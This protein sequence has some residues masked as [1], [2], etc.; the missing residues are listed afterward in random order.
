MRQERRINDHDLIFGEYFNSEAQMTKRGA[1]F[2]NL[3]VSNGIGTF[4]GS[5]SYLN[6][7]S[8]L[9]GSYTVR[10]R[11]KPSTGSGHSELLNYNKKSDSN[12]SD[13][14][15]PSRDLCKVM[16]Q[17]FYDNGITNN[18]YWSSSEDSSTRAYYVRDLSGTATQ[19][20]TPKNF[21]QS[22]RAVRYFTQGYSGKYSVGDLGVGG[23]YVFYVDGLTV[24]EEN[25]NNLGTAETWS[26]I[27]NVLIGTTGTA[28]GTGEQNTLDIINQVGH[29]TSAAKLCN[30][31]NTG[32]SSEA[33]GIGYIIK[34]SSQEI[35]TS[36]GT[37]YVNGD[38]TSTLED[39][40]WN[41]VIVSGIELSALDT[42]ELVDALFRIG[43]IGSDSSPSGVFDGDIDYV[44]IYTGIF[45]EE[46]VDNLYERKRNREVQI[47]SNLDAVDGS[48]IAQI[49][50]RSGSIVD[51]FGN[52]LTNNGVSEI[53]DGTS[54]VMKFDGSSDISFES[55]SVVNKISVWV[56]A[57]SRNEVIANFG[58]GN[59]ISIVDGTVAASWAD[60]I[61]INGQ[62]ITTIRPNVWQLVTCIS[63]SGIIPVVDYVPEYQA[64]YDQFSV[65]PSEADAAA[66]DTFVSALVDGGIWSELDR[67][68]IFAA[69]ASGTDSLLDWIHPTEAGNIATLVNAPSFIAKQGYTG[70]R[71]TSYINSNYNL[72]NDSSNYSQNNASVGVYSRILDDSNLNNGLFG[73]YIS[74]GVYCI[75]TKTAALNSG[76]VNFTN[77][78]SVGMRSLDR[79][80]STELNLFDDGLADPS[81]P[82]SNGSAGL[83]NLDL[84]IL[85]YNLSGTTQ[86]ITNAQV[87][88]A[89]MGASLGSAK[90]LAFYNAFQALMTHYGTQV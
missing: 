12:F 21:T 71:A 54:N 67:L 28:I 4:N 72:L 55:S 36:S 57:S 31:L 70:D 42:T 27:D 2:G 13:W 26:N 38:N 74:N 15:L 52:T 68:F 86:G 83:V 66:Q 69:H 34:S 56:K 76:A 17:Y 11:I 39:G 19:G 77:N 81:N 50:S 60:K 43:Y 29:T 41:E 23:G 32:S 8:K 62:A 24:Y 85:G 84:S 10:A 88:M 25:G 63:N 64:V 80:N 44:E 49:S 89:F 35:I 51:R 61:F 6:Y 75:Q 48:P 79:S 7:K 73:A 30:D 46:E 87:S 20:S 90:Q 47:A 9:N 58:G 22:V 65:K 16:C 59:T 1:S 14:F 53:K 82:L 45:S 40:E 37:I 33:E 18:N 78:A 5:S 3:T